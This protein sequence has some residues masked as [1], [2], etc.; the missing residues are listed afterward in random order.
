PK[1]VLVSVQ[2][3]GVIDGEQQSSLK[4]LKRLCQTLG[5]EVVGEVTQKRQSLGAATLVGKGKLR[6]L[7]AW[8]G[9]KGLVPKGPPGKTKATEED[10]EEEEEEDETEPL[11]LEAPP[12]P[13]GE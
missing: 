11:Y 3:P 7:A 13:T 12:A 9:G 2:L 1:A 5:F 8:T 10:E 6:E 4:E